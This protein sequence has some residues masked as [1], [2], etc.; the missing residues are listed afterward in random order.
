MKRNLKSLYIKLT[1]PI[2]SAIIQL[3]VIYMIF[4]YIFPSYD[5]RFYNYSINESKV[6][7]Q[8]S[9]IVNKCGEGFFVSWLVLDTVNKD[10]YFFKD[11]IGCNHEKGINCATS[12]KDMKLNKYYD[13]EHMID[14]GTYNF[15]NNFMTGDISYHDSFSDLNKYPT[16]KDAL[17]NTNLPIYGMALTV[18]KNIKADILYVFTISDTI[19]NNKCNKKNMTESLRNLAL[20]AKKRL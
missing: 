19:N 6:K 10:K 15:I 9:D 3:V 1:C 4:F 11:V 20:F 17:Y 13:Q 8:I 12:I 16:I 7:Q 5:N 14:N 2:V 18:V